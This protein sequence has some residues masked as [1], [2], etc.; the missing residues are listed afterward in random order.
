MQPVDWSLVLD[1]STSEAV[2]AINVAL[3]KEG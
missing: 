2:E 1:G 3:G